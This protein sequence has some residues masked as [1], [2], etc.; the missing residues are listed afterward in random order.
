MHSWPGAG[1]VRI[2]GDSWEIPAARSC[3]C[4]MA[5]ARPATP[6]KE[7]GEALGAV[8]YHAVA[9]D[10]RGMAIPTGRRTAA[11]ART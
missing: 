6:G 4:S 2:A 1:G 7:A 11:T 3:C 10:A 5:V 8:G 9:F